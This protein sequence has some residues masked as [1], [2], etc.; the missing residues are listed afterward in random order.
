MKEAFE[1]INTLRTKKTGFLAVADRLLPGPINKFIQNSA[2]RVEQEVRNSKDIVDVSNELFDLMKNKQD[3][4]ESSVVK[5]TDIKEQMTYTVKELSKQARELEEVKNSEELSEMDV[6]NAER[7]LTLISN[8]I[9]T[10]QENIQ[11]INAAQNMAMQCIMHIDQMLPTIENSMK[12]SLAINA[13][14]N[15]ISN[16]KESFTTIAEVTNQIQDSNSESIHSMIRSTGDFENLLETNV[17]GI[18]KRTKAKKQLALEMKDQGAKEKQLGARLRNAIVDAH[19]AMDGETQA[20]VFLDGDE[21][22]DYYVPERIDIG[23]QLEN[24]KK[25]KNV[26]TTKTRKVVRRVVKTKPSEEA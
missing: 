4:V 10:F 22:G 25:E 9:L 15:K 2:M 6:F 5:F 20:P 19:E 3:D 11:N 26:K 8:N 16:F 21:V 17:Q 1:K 18:Q 24:K 12:D 13:F 23:H 7:I 14:L